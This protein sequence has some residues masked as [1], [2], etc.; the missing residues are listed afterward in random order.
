MELQIEVAVEAVVHLELEEDLVEVVSLSFKR[1][2]QCR[3]ILVV[4][5]I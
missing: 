3:V 1:Q 4:S 2:M 5:G